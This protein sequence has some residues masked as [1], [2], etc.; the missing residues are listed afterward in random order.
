MHSILYPYS[1]ECPS[2]AALGFAINHPLMTMTTTWNYEHYL[3]I[4]QCLL[5]MIVE[6]GGSVLPFPLLPY[7]SAPIQLTSES[8]QVYNRNAPNFGLCHDTGPK[9]ATCRSLFLAFGNRIAEYLLQNCGNSIKNRS[10]T[11]M[12]SRVL[13]AYHAVAQNMSQNYSQ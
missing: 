13:E 2:S 4:M 11:E 6:R 3:L 8:V 7:P 9:S 5:S 10:N 12:L 1:P